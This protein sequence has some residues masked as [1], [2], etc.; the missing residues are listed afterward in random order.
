MKSAII[1]F[2]FLFLIF[3]NVS[4]GDY[5][6]ALSNGDYKAALNELI[7]LAE[8]GYAG[9]QY[10]LGWMYFNGQGVPKDYDEALRWY[11]EAADQGHAGA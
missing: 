2:T 10:S 7:P 3:P 6:E 8:K 11:R 9:A 1:L 4:R 5:H